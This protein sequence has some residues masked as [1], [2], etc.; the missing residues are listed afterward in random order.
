VGLAGASYGLF[1]RSGEV[2]DLDESIAQYQSAIGRIDRAAAPLK[3]A[4]LHGQLGIALAA[5]VPFPGRT[6]AGEAA[7]V[8]FRAALA[9]EALPAGEQ[10]TIRIALAQAISASSTDAETRR[11][12]V[13]EIREALAMF[14]K[15]QDPIAWGRAESF[16]AA[17]LFGLGAATNDPVPLEES[18]AHFRNGLSAISRERFPMEWAILQGSFGIVLSNLGWLNDDIGRLEEASEAYRAALGEFTPEHSPIEWVTAQQ[19]LADTLVELARQTSRAT[20]LEEAVAIYAEA[21]PLQSSLPQMQ[22]LQLEQKLAQARGLLDQAR[23]AA[24]AS[25]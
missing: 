20:Y 1:F 4:S 17:S 15:E 16:L 13:A 11:E 12:A 14:P 6:D 25:D 21:L 5:R 2:G 9:G 24:A 18:I 22:W 3:W 8:A 23:Q 19:N 7:I 10:A